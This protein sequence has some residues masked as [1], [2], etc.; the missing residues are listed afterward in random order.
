MDLRNAGDAAANGRTKQERKSDRELVVTRVYS[1]PA[2]HLFE[3]FTK[4]E[5]FR[6]WWVPKSFGLTLLACD[7]D[8]RSQ[9]RYRLVFKHQD[10]TMEF[11]GTYTEVVPPS[12]IR[13]TN[14]EGEGPGAITTA[15]LDERNG[16]TQ[17]T[18]HDLYPTK[19]ALEEAVA[20]G[21]PA[22]MPETLDQL[23]EL[24]AGMR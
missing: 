3:A 15:S 23:E 20:S 17:L 16:E 8:V 2:H 1:V 14:D 19:E 11:F 4:A 13:W 9:G 6:Q 18:I 21:A 12:R 7:M 10:A 24:L 5:L 22:C